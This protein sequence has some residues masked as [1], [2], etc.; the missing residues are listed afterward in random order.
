MD[1]GLSLLGLMALAA[2]FALYAAAKSVAPQLQLAP[3]DP[4]PPAPPAPRLPAVL[5]PTYHAR[6]S[7]N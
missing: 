3:R 5:A 7:L 2:G 4:T 1:R 6:F